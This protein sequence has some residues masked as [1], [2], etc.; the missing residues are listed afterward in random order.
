M[1]VSITDNGQ[2]IPPENLERIFEPSFT[3]KAGRI[4][5]GLGLGLQIV[6]D[7]VVRHNGSITVE[8][9]PGRTC[10]SVLLPPATT[11]K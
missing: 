6:K 10:F 9:E 8:S 1:Q 3:T 4:E 11:A 2:G 5:F 7:I